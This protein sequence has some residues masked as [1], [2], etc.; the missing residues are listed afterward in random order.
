MTHTFPRSR[1]TGQA[2][3]AVG[4]V[5]QWEHYLS[6]DTMQGADSRLSSVLSRSG[7]FAKYNTTISG[8]AA[9]SNLGDD[10]NWT[11]SIFSQSNTFG[12]GRLSWDP[13]LTAAEIN[14]EWTLLTFGGGNGG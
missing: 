14:K 13:T 11:G 5:K 2:V 1:Y 10:A 4:L 9:V 3:H 7:A 8:M 6:F 12:F